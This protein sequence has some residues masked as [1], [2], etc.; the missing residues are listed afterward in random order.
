L[1]VP[2]CCRLLLAGR[3]LAG[4]LVV[5]PILLGGNAYG[6]ERGPADASLLAPTLD[7]D[8]QRPSRLRARRSDDVDEGA[9]LFRR[10]GSPARP[11]SGAGLT[12]FKSNG[13]LRPGAEPRTGTVPTALVTPPA[14]AKSTAKRKG[15]AKGKP[16]VPEPKA[17]GAVPARA[18]PTLLP[19]DRAGTLDPLAPRLLQP[20]TGPIPARFRQFRPGAPP[21]DPDAE[22][23]TVASVPPTWRPAADPKPFDPLGIQAGAFLFRPGIEYSRGYD[24]NP[25][26]LG[27]QP[28]SGSW[29]NL[30][31]PD[32][33]LASNWARH[34]V[35]ATLRGSYMSF[36]TSHQN[37][38][39]NVDGRIN[40]RIDVTSLTRFLVEGRF[41]LATDYPGSPNIQADL[42]H[43]P[44]F[45]TLGASAGIGQRFNRFDITL[46]AGIDRTEYQPSVFV[47]GERLSNADRNYDQYSTTLRTT[48]DLSPQVR[49]F[50]EI[51]GNERL[52]PL[53]LDRFGLDRDSVGYSA[54]AGAALDFTRTLTGELA[55]GYLNQMYRDP[56]PNLGGF[57]VD[58]ALVWSATALTTAKLLASTITAESPLFLVSGV[59]T[60][61]VA[62]QVD[63]A[64]RRWLIGTAR[65]GYARDIYA[66]NLR[67]DNRYVAGTSLSYLLTRELWL[68][69]EFRQE[70]QRSN[71]PGSNYVAS[72]WLL[73]LRL[74]R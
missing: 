57:S 65:I 17:P 14:P 12:G 53:P 11:A 34:E 3:L 35:T 50:A 45:M 59:L 40:G 46:K 31:A 24:T 67:R 26:R 1:K 52:H 43:F 36:D 71:V 37:D 74:Q 15:R 44:I 27:L 56:L 72:I 2:H 25:A 55:A 38:R 42:A 19:P 68:K 32:L 4:T 48:Y 63:H 6:Q 33:L 64:F 73:G 18:D 29:F 30:Y 10:P 8:P 16:T 28:L 22:T 21:V 61:Q 70:W 7:G 47:D 66:G 20:A 5:S 41:I 60:R 54:K 69:G 9:P 39:P 51:S 62:F 13:G 49:P 23:V 58:G